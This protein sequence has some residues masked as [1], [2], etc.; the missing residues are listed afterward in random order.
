MFS[1]N[2]CQAA[3]RGHLYHVADSARQPNCR[4]FSGEPPAAYVCVPMTA[5]NDG[6]GTLHLQ[7]SHASL[8]SRR[9]VE[10]DLDLINSIAEYVALAIANLGMHEKLR[11]Q[12]TR[13][14]LTGLY[15]R[16]YVQEWFTLELRRAQRHGRP[17]CAL[18]LDIDHFKRVNDTFG[19][20]AGDLVLRELA[21]ALG[22]LGRKSDVVSRYGGEEFLMLLPECPL[23]AAVR[24]AELVR[25]EIEKLPFDSG[26]RP[27]G[28]VTVSI[29]VAAFPDHAEDADALLRCADDAL[30]RAKQTG[31]NRVVAYSAEPQKTGVPERA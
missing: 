15:N 17:V 14:K 20:E 27:L 7:S 13:D 9:F 5:Q 8:Q 12:A 23:G 4:H 19:H 2:D 18:M 25:Q 1:P 22:R 31:R 16:H 21:G 30:Y 6:I 3:R 24:K 10:E 26:N 11:E 29:G 28:T